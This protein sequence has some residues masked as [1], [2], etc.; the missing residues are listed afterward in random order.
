MSEAK[1]GAA[2]GAPIIE[3]WSRDGFLGERAGLVR[4]HYSPDYISV[5]GPHAP[6]RLNIGDV[7]CADEADAAALATVFATASSGLRLSVSKRRAPMPFALRNVEAEEVHFIQ[8]GELEFRTDYGVIVGVPGDFVHIPRCVAYTARPLTGAV[9]DFIVESPVSLFFDTPSP[10]GMIHFGNHVLRAQ[11]ETAPPA[12][13]PRELWLKSFDEVTVFT[14]AHDPLA[15]HRLLAAQSPVWKL[16]LSHIQPV[17]YW[18]HGGPPSH[19]LASPNNE[20]LFYTLSARPGGRP[21][22]HV[23]ADYDEIVHYF[24]GPDPWGKVSEPGTCTWV[25]KGVPHQGPSEN[26]ERGYLAFLLESRTTL[27]L[28]NAGL[29]ASQLMETGTYGRHASDQGG[30]QP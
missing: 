20:V 21:P 26:V 10:A 15:A 18:P 19:F 14:K 16:N 24:R 3:G 17:T 23:N 5:R 1:D 2:A 6:R 27:R 9:L 8:D 12:D 29:E 7:A 22:I 28:T 11:P 4:A 13:P 30:E 25:P